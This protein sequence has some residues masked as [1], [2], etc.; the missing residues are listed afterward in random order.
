MFASFPILGLQVNMLDVL[1]LIM[2]L[3][4]AI[5]CFYTY[6]RLK[7]EYAFFEN[8]F[9]LPG[10]CK[11]EDCTDPDGFFDYIGVRV[12]ILG[13]LLAVGLPLNIAAIA[14]FSLYA[15]AWVQLLPM[16]YILG[17]FAWY[18]VMQRKAATLYW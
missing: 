13:I 15:I 14:V 5:Y 16:A 9:L 6:I 18:L 17:V 2:L 12:L 3:G 10:N 1:L 4:S 7:R 8:K 11:A